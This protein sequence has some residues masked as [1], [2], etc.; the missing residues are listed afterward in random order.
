M[1][2]LLRRFWD[3]VDLSD[4]DGC[5]P[6]T[7]A[8]AR[9]GYGSFALKHGTLV[10]AHRMS[11]IIEHGPIPRDMCVLHH[12]DN[13]PCV[14]P[15]HLFLGTR[16]DNARDM[17]AKGR[18]GAQTGAMDLAGERNGRAKLTT[19]DVTEI[20]RRYAAGE[21]QVALAPIFG[22]SRAMIGN[23]VRGEAWT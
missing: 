21:T 18:H 11:W 22:V 3:K 6:W 5:W 8:T 10:P 4:P 14:N 7:A 2:D 13:P 15:A 1:S 9:R 19:E 17:A 12:C 23:I 16:G 20:R